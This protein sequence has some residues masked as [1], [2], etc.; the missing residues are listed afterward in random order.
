MEIEPKNVFL[1]ATRLKKA[2]DF[3]LKIRVD[4]EIFGDIEYVRGCSKAIKNLKNEL[5]T[6][7]NK[8]SYS[9]EKYYFKLSKEEKNN[10]E[11]TIGIVEQP[12]NSKAEINKLVKHLKK[13]F[14]KTDS[15]KFLS[16]WNTFVSQLGY[17]KRCLQIPECVR[18]KNSWF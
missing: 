2:C 5:K 16:A 6:L 7:E 4:K 17:M 10:I 13:Y 12:F 3:Y 14:N 11:K 18:T 1:V 8:I 15:K 9:S